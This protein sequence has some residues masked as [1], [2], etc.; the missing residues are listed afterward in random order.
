ARLPVI[1]QR[2]GLTEVVLRTRYEAARPATRALRELLRATRVEYRCPADAR[3]TGLKG[4]SMDFVCSSNVL[5]H[6]APP[7]LGAIPREASRVLK[8]G[9]LA[10]HRF[11]PEDHFKDVDKSITAVNFLQFSEREWRWYGG[12]GLG[13][14]NRLRCSQHRRLLQEA[15]FKV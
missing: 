12:S 10:V 9:G 1:A 3:R 8:P 7:D 14:H 11:N 15:G 4:A 2:L 5:Q 13:Y 6:V